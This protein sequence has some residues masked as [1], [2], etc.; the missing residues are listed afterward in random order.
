MKYSLNIQFDQAGLKTVISAQQRVILVKTILNLRD[1]KLVW[2][3]FAPFQYNTIDWQ[4]AYF[5]YAAYS[6]QNI[7]DSVTSNLATA[8]LVYELGPDG[9][10]TA[11][12]A[13]D[14]SGYTL[15]NLLNNS[16]LNTFGLS[17][18][19]IINGESLALAPP[20]CAVAL[21][22]NN[23]AIF[24]PSETVTVSMA[25][26]PDVSSGALTVTLTPSAPSQTIHYQDS[27]NSFQTGPLPH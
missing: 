23:V 4:D 8:G 25:S 1:N 7:S 15:K 12:D 17:Q 19:A 2:V 26:A 21:S 11:G 9:I 5:F 18:A 22:Y 27:T 20:I 24:K 10:S 14:P 3:S 6:S 13:G 16:L